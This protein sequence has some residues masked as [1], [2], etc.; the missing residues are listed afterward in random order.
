M[1]C[2]K[3]KGMVGLAV[4]RVGTCQE[5]GGPA[6]SG[7]SIVPQICDGCSE[8]LGECAYCRTAVRKPRAKCD[9]FI[10]I[11]GETCILEIYVAEDGYVVDYG[12]N[13]LNEDG[14]TGPEIDDPELKYIDQAQ[15]CYD[16]WSEGCWEQ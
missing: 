9:T 7:T 14:T 4:V 1:K 11:D 10:E 5:C 2:E 3:H 6:S 8:R 15:R 13:V 16:G 12:I